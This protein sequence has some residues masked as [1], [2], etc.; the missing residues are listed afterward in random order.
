MNLYTLGFTQK[1]AEE[2]FGL[3]KLHKITTLIDIRRNNNTQL[4]GFTKG[5]DLAYFLKELCECKYEYC[6]EYAPNKEIFE[7]YK[8]KLITWEN[9]AQRYIEIM[10]EKEA[11]KNFYQRFN[12]KINICLLCSEVKPNKCHRRLLAE[13]IKANYPDK[14]EILHI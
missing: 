2:F 8:K 6:P 12:R 9:Y 14:I 5:K 3:I 11:V 13:M 7:A 1:S 10:K 4:L